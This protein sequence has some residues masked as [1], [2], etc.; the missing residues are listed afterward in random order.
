MDSARRVVDRELSLRVGGG[1]RPR[2]QT[3][4]HQVSCLTCQEPALFLYSADRQSFYPGNFPNCGGFPRFR[5][6]HFLITAQSTCI[7]MG[8]FLKR[9]P[10]FG[11][12]KFDNLLGLKVHLKPTKHLNAHLTRCYLT[13]DSHIKLKQTT[14]RTLQD[15]ETRRMKLALA[16]P[17]YVL[18]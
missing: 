11:T 10:A 2:W 17:R 16:F 18:L 5:N 7:T 6:P 3:V 1:V 8:H 13:L 15:P 14:P 9:I 12:G 4:F